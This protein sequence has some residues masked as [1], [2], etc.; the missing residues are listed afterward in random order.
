MLFLCG[1]RSVLLVVYLVILG[2]GGLLDSCLLIIL[3][4]FSLF[5]DVCFWLVGWMLLLMLAVCVWL[6]LLQFV[7]LR[8][9][10]LLA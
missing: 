7:M 10:C 9:G 2:C 6:L 4:P 8:L 5:V 3:F 1:Y